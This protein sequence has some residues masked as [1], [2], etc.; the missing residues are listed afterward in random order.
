[1]FVR[2]KSFLWLA[3][4]FFAAVLCV[5]A[6]YGSYL[7]RQC[8]APMNPIDARLFISVY[9]N[10]RVPLWM[11][12]DTV[13]I[14]NGSECVKYLTPT[15]GATT[16]TPIE[17]KPDSGRGYSGEGS[18]VAGFSSPPQFQTPVWYPP[19]RGVPSG[20]V[21]VGPLCPPIN[22]YLCT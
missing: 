10:P 1:M 5:A 11:A 12:N 6:D 18:P 13:T 19:N 2:K 22:Q 14:C 15:S 21:T 16:W 4:G 17:K 7:C 8:A 3:F 20:S 9:V